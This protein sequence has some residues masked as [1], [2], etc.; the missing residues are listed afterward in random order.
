MKA[1]IMIEKLAAGKLVEEDL[2]RWLSDS[3]VRND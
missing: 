1:V 3:S 2:S